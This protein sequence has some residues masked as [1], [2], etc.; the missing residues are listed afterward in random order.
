MAYLL[1]RG[2]FHEMIMVNIVEVIEWTRI[3]LQADGQMERQIYGHGETNRH[4][5]QLHILLFARK[6]LI[7]VTL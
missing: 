5:Q 3:H 1:P 2:Y 6:W 7:F 4:P